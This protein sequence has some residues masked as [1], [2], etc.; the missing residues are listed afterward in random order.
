M[1]HGTDSP[2]SLS[3][4]ATARSLGSRTASRLLAAAALVGVSFSLVSGQVVRLPLPGQGGGLLPSDGAVVVLAVAA[5]A[6]AWQT[7]RLVM[8]AVHYTLLWT[9]FAAVSAGL[10]IVFA[11]TLPPG[12]GAI[13]AA[14][15]VRL[16]A[17]VLVLPALLELTLV[18]TPAALHRTVRWTMAALL[19]FGA[20]QL[21]LL[22]NLQSLVPAGWDPHQGRLVST[23][24][25]PN[26]FGAACVM[27]ACYAAAWSLNTLSGKAQ[28]T[29]LKSQIL[30]NSEKRN[31]PP[32]LVRAFGRVFT[33]LFG[34]WTVWI[35]R[36]HSGKLARVWSF[37]LIAASLAALLATQSRGS[38]IAAAAAALIFIPAAAP[39]LQRLS[40][41]RRRAVSIL[42]IAAALTVAAA[43][44]LLHQRLTG[45]L[46]PD[47]T[48]NL[49]RDALS[50]VWPLAREHTLLGVGY[51]TYQFTARQ[52]GLINDFTVH[53]RAGADNSYL[54]LWITTGLP[55]LVLF[56]LP[57][58]AVTRSLIVRA[59]RTAD[60]YPAAAAAAAA[61]LAVHALF[62]NSL[63]YSHLLLILS[64]II[65]AA[66]SQR[67]NS[68]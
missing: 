35:P 27:M 4:L 65:A 20:L 48:Y 67:N 17:G 39:S 1:V 41:S 28:S 24:L 56:L 32:R 38:F 44:P 45:L 47:A 37:F 57:A 11:P 52:V 7:R 22:P 53:S 25:D 12:A 58:A 15:W 63:L 34:F 43:M 8:S 19:L 59:W 62:V 16:F 51:N 64:L 42:A 21:F 5:G 23:W 33:V 40:A 6:V 2:T 29:K 30:P 68:T 50:A 46:W 18:V 13:A 54:T 14:Y 61:A 3:P 36:I 49:R 60:P 66:L 9:P 55:G 10:V 26:Y 31:T